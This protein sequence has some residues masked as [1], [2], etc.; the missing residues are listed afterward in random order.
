MKKLLN[1][2]SHNLTEDQKKAVGDSIC[3]DMPAEVKG[4]WGQVPVDGDINSVK[5]HVQPVIDWILAENTGETTALIAG[6]FSASFLVME[7]CWA[8]GIKTVE[9]TTKRKVIEETM[10]DGSVKKTSVFEFV[11]FREIRSLI[12]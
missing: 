5:A 2:T 3:V 12:S 9:A 11:Q 7:V 6:A 4:K 10:P 1:V 8:S